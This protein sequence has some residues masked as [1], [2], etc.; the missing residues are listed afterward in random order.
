MDDI[1]FYEND[2]QYNLVDNEGNQ[3]DSVEIYQESLVK[4][5]KENAKQDHK[6][7]ISI[8]D[9]DDINS[10]SSP[11]V[12]SI[13]SIIPEGTVINHNYTILVSGD[14]VSDNTISDNII[15]KP[16]NQ[17]T[18]QEGLTLLSCFMFLVFGFVVIVRKGVIPWN[19]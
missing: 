3:D 18:T 11:E 10:L 17:Y 7:D 2:D 12:V 14:E 19:W 4:E 9:N 16:L 8:F 5:V 6:S 13:D 15:C 1:L